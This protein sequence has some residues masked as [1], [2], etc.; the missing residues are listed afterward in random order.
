MNTT[1][2]D[3]AELVRALEELALPAG[4]F[5]HRHHL[6]AAW[7]MLGEA[8]LLATLERFPEALR[9]FAAHHGEH[10]L[11][12]ETITWYFLLLVNERREQLE[13]GHNWSAFEAANKD[14]FQPARVALEAA[15]TKPCLE[16]DLAKRTFVLPA[17]AGLL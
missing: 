1:P 13:P 2:T 15:Y 3:S 10:D 14:L 17:R 11:Y 16:S 5:L 6:Q 4:G 9:R 12:H 8:G 7:W